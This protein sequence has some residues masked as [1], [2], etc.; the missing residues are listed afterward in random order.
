MTSHK[1]IFW[2]QRDFLF[3]K[4]WFAMVSVSTYV[5]LLG[6][7]FLITGDFLFWLKTLGISGLA[8]YAIGALSCLAG[9]AFFTWSIAVPFIIPSNK[10]CRSQ[11]SKEQ[12]I[13][14][15]TVGGLL[16]FTGIDWGGFWYLV[17]FSVM[18][19]VILIA[20]RWETH[21]DENGQKPKYPLG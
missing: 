7:C 20:T 13:F 16:W 10:L 17:G 11:I 19:F 1:K 9:F 21:Q 6:V 8:Y 3:S 12:L 4:A 5:I 15:V 18:L 2:L 14:F